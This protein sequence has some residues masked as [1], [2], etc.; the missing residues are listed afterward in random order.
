M[1]GIIGA[2]TVRAASAES[3][4]VRRAPESAGAAGTVPCRPSRRGGD[5]AVKGVCPCLNLRTLEVL[6]NSTLS[7][8]AT[9]MVVRHFGCAPCIVPSAAT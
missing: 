7:C 4:G 5:V 2:E 8:C 9:V 1:H 6:S 3:P